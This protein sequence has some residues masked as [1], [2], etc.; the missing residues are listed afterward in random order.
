NY[1]GVYLDLFGDL[2]VP[3][4]VSERSRYDAVLTDEEITVIRRNIDYVNPIAW[5]VGARLGIGQIA[6]TASYRLT[7]LID[8]EV[9]PD[10][11]LPPLLLGLSMGL[12]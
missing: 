10:A 5:Q 9:A 2:L 6:L 12:Y 3:F 4:R 1:A 7:P 11:G 8:E